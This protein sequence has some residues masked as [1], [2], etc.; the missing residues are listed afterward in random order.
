[1][2]HKWFNFL[3]LFVAFTAHCRPYHK[4]AKRSPQQKQQQAVQ[5][6]RSF[7][8][9]TK[10]NSMELRV[11]GIECALCAQTVIDIV[12]KY[13]AQEVQVYDT[14]NDY[15]H[16]YLSFIWP[17]KNKNIAIQKVEQAL[18]KEGFE[19]VFIKGSFYGLFKNDDEKKLTVSFED[20]DIIAQVNKTESKKVKLDK[21]VI[22]SGTL[23]IKSSHYSFQ[24]L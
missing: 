5:R 10:K 19:L 12:A 11:E 21:L 22:A 23:S 3:L 15:E 18:K 8:R 14:A 20:E 24:L 2:V 7:V 9:R 1:M 6:Q 13:G 4:R 16:C 17:E